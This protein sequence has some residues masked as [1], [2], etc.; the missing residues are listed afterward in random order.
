MKSAALPWQLNQMCKYGHQKEL[1]KQIL[2]IDGAMGTDATLQTSGKIIVAPG[3]KT[4]YW[5]KGNNDLLSIYKP[6]DHRRMHL[7]Y[8]KAGAD[9]V[10]TNNPA[11]I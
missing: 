3:S 7:R 6:P 8:L 4:A 2:I 10:E 11:R 9:I 5:C 1:E